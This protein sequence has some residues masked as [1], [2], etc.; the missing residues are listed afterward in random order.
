MGLTRLLGAA[1]LVLALAGCAR[2]PA[3][4]SAPVRPAVAGVTRLG[5]TIQVG[6]FA[7]LENAVRLADTLQSLGENATYYASSPQEAPRRLYRVR[8]GNFPTREAARARAEAIRATGVIQEFYLVAPEEP[9]LARPSPRDEDGLRANLVDTAENYRGVPYLW[10][11]TTDQGFDCSGLAMAV[12]RLNGLQLPR[13][14]REQFAAGAPVARDEL[15]KG[16]LVFFARSGRVSHVGIYVGGDSFIHAPKRGRSITRE[17]LS[18]YYATHF[19]GARS[20][21]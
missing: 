11:G 20:Y 18:G 1:A 6:A 15:R 4:G 8:F 7:Q 10:G 17:K 21:L 3:T 9:P 19:A 16:D 12:Y 5:F 13:T 14:S 2:G